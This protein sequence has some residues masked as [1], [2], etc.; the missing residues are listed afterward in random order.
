MHLRLPVHAPA[1]AFSMLGKE[2]LRAIGSVQDGVLGTRHV[3]DTKA[4]TVRKQGEFE[5]TVDLVSVCKGCGT[6]DQEIRGLIEL[7]AKV[8]D[9]VAEKTGYHLETEVLRLG[10]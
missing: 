9:I 8:R 7:I 4:F 2:H 1:N 10:E 3:A 6:A 5:Q